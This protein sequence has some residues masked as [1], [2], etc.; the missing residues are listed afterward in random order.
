MA[1]QHFASLSDSKTPPQDKRVLGPFLQQRPVGWATTRGALSAH[2]FTAPRPLAAVPPVA[3]SR[4]H[5]NYDRPAFRYRSPIG[6][7]IRPSYATSP[8]LAKE[9]QAAALFPKEI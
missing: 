1:Q 8:A 5:T 6:Q 4:L 2:F 9:A 7:V 3:K